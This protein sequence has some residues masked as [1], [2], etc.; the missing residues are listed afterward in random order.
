MKS[1]VLYR[2]SFIIEIPY[3]GRNSSFQKLPTASFETGP[4]SEIET[5]TFK[6]CIPLHL[7]PVQ[8]PD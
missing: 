7:K 2:N 1:D 8:A 3:F 5:L 6:N 4:S